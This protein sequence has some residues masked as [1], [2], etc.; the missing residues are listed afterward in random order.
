MPR[1]SGRKLIAS[2][3]RARHD[4]HLEDTYEAGLVLVGTEVKSLRQGRASLVDGFVDGFG[5]DWLS[6]TALAAFLAALG[7]GGALALQLGASQPA[8][9]GAGVAAGAVAGVLAGVLTRRLSPHA[10]TGRRAR[11]GQGAVDV[12]V[13]GLTDVRWHGPAGRWAC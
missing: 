3:R 9:I 4:F 1:E 2:N 6:G 8:A 13:C 10:R 12:E 11:R 7:F 5:P